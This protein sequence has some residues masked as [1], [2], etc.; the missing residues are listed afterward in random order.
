MIGLFLFGCFITAVVAAAC[1][2]IVQGIQE[3]R[4]QLE[5]YPEDSPEYPSSNGFSQRLRPVRMRARR[6]PAR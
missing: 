5:S 3:D 2:I 6:P 1:F 4:R